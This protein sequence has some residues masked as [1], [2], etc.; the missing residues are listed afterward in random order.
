[1]RGERRR[2]GDGTR[3]RCAGAR[4]DRPLASFV[5]SHGFRL[6][7]D[8]GGLDDGALAARIAD[9]P[10]PPTYLLN[11]AGRC[12]FDETALLEAAVRIARGPRA[13]SPR[14]APPPPAT[15][16]AGARR[17]ALRR[18]PTLDEAF[19]L[20]FSS[21]GE[22]REGQLEMARA[23]ERALREAAVA[24]VEAGTGTGK[25]LG[26]LV[27][28][29]LHSLETEER[30]VVSTHTK[31]LQDQLY[32]KELPLLER[33]LGI[34]ARS[35]RLLGRDNY[36]CTR[37]LV[38][39]ALSFGDDG[40][41]LALGLAAAIAGDGLV[42]SIACAAS[43]G[44]GRGS[45]AVAAGFAKDGRGGDA[46][47]A[48]PARCA[49]NACVF[50]ERCPLLRAR[51]DA[52]EARLL[53]VNHALLLTDYRQGGGVIGPYARV[54]F[55]EAHQL[56]RC[57]VENLS[58]KA[59]RDDMRRILEPL[60]L[61]EKDEDAWRLL[62]HELEAALP[63]GE[64][65]GLR[66]RVAREARELERAYLHFFEAVDGAV[67]LSRSLRG[68]KARYHDG[69]ETFALV[70][71]AKSD[72]ILKNNELQ[73]SLKLVYRAGVSRD[74]DAFRQEMEY[75][76][77]ELGALEDAIRY[78]T[79]GLD[80]ESV[81]WLD[82]DP[83]GSLRELCGSPLSVARSFADYLES[84]LGTAVFTSAT[85]S[86][87][88]SFA[89]LKERLGLRL[90]PS[91][92]IEAIIPSPFPFDRNCL[93]LIVT[94]LGDPNEDAFAA[95]VSGI[96]SAIGARVRRRAMV[97]C[98]SY[99]LCRAV[100][101]TLGRS[102]PGT[103]LF[104][105]GEGES[106]EAL[107]AGFRA[108]ENAVLLGVAS[109]WEGVD[110]PGEELEVLVIPKVPFPVP[111]EPIVEA[112]SER[113]RALGEDPFERLFLPEA[114]LRM[115]QGAGRLIR[116]ESDRGVIVV[117]DERLETRPYGAQ[118]LAALPSRNVEHVTAEECAERVAEWFQRR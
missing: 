26:Y 115:R 66:R 42:E 97:L 22:R 41:A 39:N 25:S 86:Q 114:I 14:L 16:A 70:G 1:M 89:F 19:D 10:V 75:V 74:L 69:G 98:T 45:A 13:A 103:R 7:L 61:A 108:S 96:V 43:A 33:L 101:R 9:G 82:W 92:P 51:K 105:Q 31:N 37:G 56:E 64:A 85:I 12:G 95:P 40:R 118:V 104:V 71:D 80:E 91:R 52:R 23:V 68:T 60:R 17:G 76:S 63:A 36:L 5:R 88:G 24:L 117:L 116:R 50:A 67:N 48:P 53:F 59:A 79:T 112:R 111:A 15:R 57:V 90:L 18:T 107:S 11:L 34:D 62:G 65:K 109:F 106:R 81:F 21:L 77:E 100:A 38:S 55:D 94:G 93:V 87:E 8:A 73:S 113:H 20:V 2:A 44:G 28:A 46:A 78:L 84:F 32:R 3:R 35:S 4:G 83:G 49:M 30:V 110:F 58:V 99:R 54:V 27:P 29:V 47:L 102:S 6:D 72:I